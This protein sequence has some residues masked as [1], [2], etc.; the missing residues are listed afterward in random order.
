MKL[1]KKL[2][3]GQFITSVILA[4]ID[5]DNQLN[6]GSAQSSF[7]FEFHPNTFEI[8]FD[9]IAQL[10][11]VTTQN[12]NN[13][14][15]YILTACLRLF[16]THL[17]YLCAVKSN[18]HRDYL[19]TNDE[20]RKTLQ[21]S[22]DNDFDITRFVNEEQLTNWFKLLLNLA[23]DK[24]QTPEQKTISVE[25][26]KAIVCLIHQRMSSFTEKLSFMHR[27]IVESQHSTLSNQLMIE[28]NKNETL[29]CWIDILSDSNNNN[30]DKT[31]A[32]QILHSF[33]E[34][35]FNPPTQM[36]KEQI[37]QIEKLLLLFQQF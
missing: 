17:K 13:V 19:S 11:T 21:H 23:H 27:Y 25:A 10:T 2:F 33:I 28:L 35:C 18:F 5:V 1:D 8:L 9:I 20:M 16:T 6:C 4:H 31:T 3:T 24:D 37:Q 29:L 30:A 26:S 22:S 36:D 12:S 32:M 34:I 14:I 15:A 7:S